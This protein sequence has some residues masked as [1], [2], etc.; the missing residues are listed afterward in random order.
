MRLPFLQVHQDDLARGRILARILRVSEAHATGIVVLLDA[1]ALGETE[2]GI[3]LDSDPAGAVA[4]AVGWEGD[5]GALL[6]GLVRVRLI[7]EKDGTF[8]VAGTSRYDAALSSPVRRSEAGRVAATG[9]WH[10]KKDANRM[11]SASNRNASSMRIDAKTQ[12]QTQIEDL[13]P[14]L[15]AALREDFELEAVAQKPA[16]KAK[17]AKK[18]TD[19]RHAPLTQELCEQ[20][21]WPH[22]GGRTAKAISELIRL[23]DG[24]TLGTHPEGA[25]AEVLRRAAL[26]RVHVGFPTVRELHELVTHW[27]HFAEP[28][29][30]GAG[31]PRQ[32][33]NRGIVRN[34][35]ARCAVCGNET[36]CADFG[37]GLLLCYGSPIYGAPRGCGSLWR[38]AIDSGEWKP[39]QAAEWAAQRRAA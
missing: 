6:A 12:T 21:G 13:P 34:D 26:A 16:K 33:P 5:A 37:G 20:L 38:E 2:G 9:R 35:V 36:E 30:R 4:L 19:P 15:S 7:D 32:D 1:W 18:L 24:M 14:P 23:A 11:V 29:R 28:Q 3:I 25:P 22:H 10:G 27:G 8:R 31:Q 17:E 39:E